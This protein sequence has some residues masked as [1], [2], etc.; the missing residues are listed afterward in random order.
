MTSFTFD[1][2]PYD[3]LDDLQLPYEPPAATSISVPQPPVED[4]YS[5]T[6]TITLRMPKDLVSQVDSL[7][8][9]EDISR[10]H[11]MRRI[12]SY[13]LQAIRSEPDAISEYRRVSSLLYSNAVEL[14]ERE[15]ELSVSLL[16]RHFRLD[17]RMAT[18]LKDE[19]ERTGVVVPAANAAYCKSV[20]DD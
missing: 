20:I 13:V 6:K 14:V 12:T 2:P 7:A 18:L 10:S 3:P 1:L 11:A 15:R 17:F 19:L 9:Q 8:R 5:T 4:D 16:Q